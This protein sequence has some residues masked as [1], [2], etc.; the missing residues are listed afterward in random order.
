MARQRLTIKMSGS[1]RLWVEHVD[2]D[3]PVTEAQFREA[4]KAAIDK[5]SPK[6]KASR[7]ASANRKNTATRAEDKS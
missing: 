2:V 6:Q 5:L 4:A 1:R 3:A 7:P